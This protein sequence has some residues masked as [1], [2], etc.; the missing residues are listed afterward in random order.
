MFSDRILGDDATL[1]S[2]VDEAD[3]YTHIGTEVLHLLRFICVNAMAARKILKKHDKLLSKKMLGTYYESPDPQLTSSKSE[4][5]RLS[6]G[7]DSHLRALCNG[8]GIA[9][10]TASLLAALGEFQTA[11]NR[12]E[13]ISRHAARATSSAS[14]GG[15]HSLKLDAHPHTLVSSFSP[16]RTSLSQ[17]SSSD[18]LN[19]NLSD[20]P[21]P[22]LASRDPST[23]VLLPID[24]LRNTVSS[25][26]TV[27]LVADIAYHP[28]EAFLSRRALTITGN[29]LGDMGGASVDAL[30]FLLKYDPATAPYT[31]ASEM[32]TAASHNPNLPNSGETMPSLDSPFDSPARQAEVN[33][34]LN[35]LSVFL[36]TT[37]YYIVSPTANS[38][39]ELLHAPNSSFGGA[40]VGAA[41]TSAFIAAFVYSLWV[42]HF[43]FSF[44]SALL[45]SAGAATIG[46]ALYGFALTNE[47]MSTA[48]LGRFLVGFGSAE[49]AN[50]LF[51]SNF[52]SKRDITRSCAKFV[53]ASALGMSVGPLLAGILDS[54]AGRD[55]D[56]DID[57]FGGLI[58]NH[59]TMPGW[60]MMLAWFC[61][62]VLLAL[63]FFEDSR[64]AVRDELTLEKDV[65]LPRPAQA[66]SN[67]EEP[68]AIK[69]TPLQPVAAGDSDD[70]EDDADGSSNAE[71]SADRD[72]LV[73]RG[74]T[75]PS[76][77]TDSPPISPFAVLDEKQALLKTSAKSKLGGG[78]AYGSSSV[79]SSDPVNPP[80]G[81]STTFLLLLRTHAK[82]VAHVVSDYRKHFFQNKAFPVMLF[83]FGLI[84]LTDEI[85]IN[86]V[87]LITRRYFH[88]HGAGAGFLIASLMVFVLPANF[89][90]DKL[91]SI[92]DERYLAK[93]FTQFC[94]VG[95]VFILNFTALLGFASRGEGVRVS[96][97]DVDV[98]HAD[99]HADMWTLVQKHL[100]DGRFGFY[101][102]VF[103]IGW[104][105]MGTIMLEGVVTSMLAKSAPGSLEADFLNAGLLATLVGTL[106][107]VAGDGI[108]VLAGLVHDEEK[109]DY[110][111]L[112]FLQVLLLFSGGAWLLYRYYEKLVTV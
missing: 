87:A 38:F 8:A 88:W 13:E 110:V 71:V 100:Y 6:G 65:T 112:Q 41:S 96:I 69:P 10:I 48:Y 64:T 5:H 23:V 95:V 83:L 106:G 77:T 51:I 66:L 59:V 98:D 86:S 34:I 111:N 92:Y 12:A 80:A 55:L 76:G 30:A 24:K 90:V 75:S 19:P 44:K 29:K 81:D 107:R 101:Q 97:G 17:S 85:L 22:R 61:Q 109:Y 11:H 37:N 31:P 91:S 36:Y 3:A 94:I 56:V 47:S 18:V 58:L 62:F 82:K 99:N 53:A 102:Y 26:T 73:G 46:N 103:C 1:M 40:L 67:L 43:Q 74:K 63:F 42:C 20:I 89:V 35:L 33:E 60:L 16:L 79:N 14:N 2:A 45:F 32:W 84:E 15:Y 52:V 78:L 39:A 57:I 108:V 9:A 105:F 28:F 50:R 21:P 25:I 68:I 54:R 4:S 93:K 27:R 104:I 7:V 49:V 70:D 72:G